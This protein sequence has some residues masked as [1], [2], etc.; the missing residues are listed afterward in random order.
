LHRDD[1]IKFSVETITAMQTVDSQRL[2]HAQRRCGDKAESCRTE[3]IN[4]A[5]RGS[6]LNKKS[7]CARTA[8][9]PDDAHSKTAPHVERAGAVCWDSKDI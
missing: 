6:L 8:R 7:S 4:N 2:D 1:A 3:S 5:P 9:G